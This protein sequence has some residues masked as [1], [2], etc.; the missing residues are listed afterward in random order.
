[1]IRRTRMSIAD[2]GWKQASGKKPVH[3]IGEEDD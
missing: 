2:S 3:W 1:M